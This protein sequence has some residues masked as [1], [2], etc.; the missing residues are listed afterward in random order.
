M[1][2]QKILKEING[3]LLFYIS[4]SAFSKNFR[5]N[6]QKLVLNC[7]FKEIFEEF[8][9]KIQKILM[10]INEYLLRYNFVKIFL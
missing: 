1:K 4:V 7:N 9:W 5:G 6:S 8:P 10:K 2:I 3:F